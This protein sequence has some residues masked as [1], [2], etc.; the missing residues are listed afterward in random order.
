METVAVFTDG[1]SSDN[2]K[3]NCKCS[4]GVYI[5]NTQKEYSLTL[6][7]ACE[8]AK[9]EVNKHSNNVGELMAILVAL[10]VTR[11]EKETIIYSDSMYCINSITLWSKKWALNSWKNSAGKPVENQ[12][13]IKEILK[14]KRNAF[15]VHVKA[16]TKEPARDD[17]NYSK[18]YG[19]D[20]ADYL[21]GEAMK[22]Y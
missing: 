11:D 3:K 9:F 2:G 5:E 22:K 18:W 7:E 10:T 1:S 6:E 17:P 12:E 16:H 13:L 15:F 14:R 19:N 4:S 21:A 20:R 8:L